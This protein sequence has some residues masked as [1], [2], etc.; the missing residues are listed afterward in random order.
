MEANGLLIPRSY[1]IQA[2]EEAIQGNRVINIRT[3]VQ[4]C[5]SQTLQTIG[6]IFLCFA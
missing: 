3:G 4:F 5:T 2:A 1:Q 6:Q